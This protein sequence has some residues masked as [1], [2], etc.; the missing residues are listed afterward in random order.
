M[1]LHGNKGCT[2]YPH[3]HSKQIK[4]QKKFEAIIGILKK[5]RNIFLYCV[6][7]LSYEQFYNITSKCFKTV[8]RK[9]NKMFK[10]ATTK[11]WFFY[12][13]QQR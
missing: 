5:N 3:N 1:M 7:S 8:A 2:I 12:F 6:K 13:I 9:L 11:L 4:F 10:K